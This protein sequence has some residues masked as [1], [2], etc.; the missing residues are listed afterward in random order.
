MKTW[1][2][3]CVSTISSYAGNQTFLTAGENKGGVVGQLRDMRRRERVGHFPRLEGGGDFLT[4]SRISVRR[5]EPFF[6][7]KA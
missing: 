1:G 4:Q 6:N 7:S 5:K 2:G 3:G